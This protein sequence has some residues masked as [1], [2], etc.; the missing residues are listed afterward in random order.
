MQLSG[1]LLLIASSDRGRLALQVE[2]LRV[3]EL[4]ESVRN[5]FAWRAAEDGRAPQWV[6]TTPDGGAF[7]IGRASRLR[8]VAIELRSVSGRSS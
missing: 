5:R 3:W 7:A 8:Y 6:A 1:D 4:L 2:P